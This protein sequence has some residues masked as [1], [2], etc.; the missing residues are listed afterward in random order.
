MLLSKMKIGHK[1]LIASSICTILAGCGGG[2]SSGGG[3]SK[4]SNTAPTIDAISPL[5]IQTLDS[6]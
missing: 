1:T 3:D 4:P 6:K 5:T 2:G